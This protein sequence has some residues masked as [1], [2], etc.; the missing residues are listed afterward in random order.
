MLVLNVTDHIR[1]N[2]HNPQE[3]PQKFFSGTHPPLHIR[4]DFP[5]PTKMFT[6]ADTVR[7]VGEAG[8]CCTVT[9]V[10]H[11]SCAYVDVR[12]WSLSTPLRIDYGERLIAEMVRTVGSRIWDQKRD[13][14]LS[15]KFRILTSD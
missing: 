6:T 13:L 12:V 11:Y 8:R 2:S 14:G 9:A 15:Q 4:I 3:A 5:W 10:G 1:T 7:A